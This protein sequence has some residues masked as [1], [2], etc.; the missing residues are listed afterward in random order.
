M[1]QFFHVQG[2]EKEQ[3]TFQ[4]LRHQEYQSKNGGH[5]DLPYRPCGH[6][7]KKQDQTNFKCESETFR[8]RKCACI[9]VTY[10]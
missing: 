6:L 5:V 1:I 4:A 9:D 8:Y 2:T 3:K 7:T 10:F